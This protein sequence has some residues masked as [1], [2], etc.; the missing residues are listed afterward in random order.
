MNKIGKI[1]GFKERQTPNDII[2]TPISLAKILINMADI[3]PNDKVLDPS[4]GT[5]IFFNNLSDCKKDW[6]EIT[7]GKDF[8]NYNEKVDIII[9]N[10]P[11]SQWKKWLSH[12]AILNPRKICY[13][14]GCLNLT[15]QRINFLKAHGYILSK[16]HLTTVAGWFGNIMCVVFDKE[17]NECITHDVIRHKISY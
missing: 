6:C 8:F 10:P 7:D 14:M 2:Y 17:G 4:R 9:G 15:P 5:G 3:Q 13:I 16:I 1:R 12:S 11:F